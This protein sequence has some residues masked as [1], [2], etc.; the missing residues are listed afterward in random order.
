L[1]KGHPLARKILLADDSVTAQN[2]GRKILTDAGYEVMTV[3]N[4]S[5]ALKRVTE[6][7]PDLIVL[8]VYMPGYSG[9]EV[10]QRLKDSRETSRIPVLLTVGKLEPFKPEDARRVAADAF[11]V[12]PFEASE[13]LSALTR[14][15]DRI[16][17]EADGSRFSTNI[18]GIDR[19]AGDPLAKKDSSDTGEQGWK[20]RIRFPSKKAKKEEVEP[21][22]DYVTPTAFRE[23][24]GGPAEKAGETKAPAQTRSERR[25]PG[26]VPDIPRDITPDELDALSAL[27]AK[28]DGPIPQ[29]EAISPIGDK[30]GASDS[31]P[32]TK[33]EAAETVNPEAIA[34]PAL[35]AEA[36]DEVASKAAATSAADSRPE[37]IPAEVA[38]TRAETVAS[39]YTPAPIDRDDEPLF[40]T[41]AA[42]V[43]QADA[44]PEASASEQ[45]EPPAPAIES[46]VPQQVSASMQESQP[47]FSRDDEAKTDQ[48]KVEEMV[49]EAVAE[50]AIAEQKAGEDRAP[51]DE[52]LAEALRLLTP[53]HGSPSEHVDAAAND[54]QPR[55]GPDKAVELTAHA[56][57]G[58]R[59]TA[60]P[61]ELSSEE[62]SISLE[63]EMFRALAPVETPAAIAAAAVQTPVTHG[64]ADGTERAAIAEGTS[65]SQPA[66]SQAVA[67]SAAVVEAAACG[68]AAENNE[69]PRLESVV[70]PQAQEPAP[71][72]FASQQ[73]AA[74]SDSKGSESTIETAPEHVTATTAASEI[75]EEAT[76]DQE[77]MSK[78][79]KTDHGKSSKSGWHQIHAAA[80]AANTDVET[81]KHTEAEP[82]AEES[83][84]AMA[85]A[86]ASDDA[87]SSTAGPDPNSIASIVDS[88]LAD[89][90][91]RIVEEIAKKLSKK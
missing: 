91:P 53:V 50:Q 10:C 35:K 89:L 21:E 59:W 86:A 52:E 90:R 9:L 1:C 85:A 51:T 12:K 30:I 49:A 22:P 14:L 32:E 33:A 43:S 39:E 4:G 80:P 36:N 6:Q 29:A 18:T 75:D 87:L 88:V 27:V 84:K 57:N 78:R 26:L 67:A 70:E 37:P 73:A 8:D 69:Q 42:A 46:S 60:V 47:A 58:S 5:A 23:L 34:P 65:A 41:A 24:R 55:P 71:V 48:V 77:S 38:A 11:I 66:L 15:E 64:A 19:F 3:N 25:E 40:A 81:A 62:M 76:G 83:L 72:T 61:V 44:E 74:D 17:P 20:S 28:L 54:G 7:K 31:A 13:L 63:A 82:Q 68:T 56:G 45:S 2:M 79:A 16:V